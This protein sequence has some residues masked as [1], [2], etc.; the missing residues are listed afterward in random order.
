VNNRRTEKKG[1]HCSYV[2]AYL[3]D[4]RRKQQQ[5]QQQQQASE[6]S[7]LHPHPS[8]LVV[9]AGLRN[10]RA[11]YNRPLSDSCAN[12]TA[13]ADDDATVV[14]LSYLYVPRFFPAVV[15]VRSA[16]PGAYYIVSPPSYRVIRLPFDPIFGAFLSLGS[17]QL[18]PYSRQQCGSTIRFGSII[19]I[20]LY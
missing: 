17:A 12:I 6:L 18:G 4:D 7:L 15:D 3:F 13:Y 11:Q 14:I 5:Q 8:D 2:R 1:A 10:Y 16:S 20:A 19:V 9:F